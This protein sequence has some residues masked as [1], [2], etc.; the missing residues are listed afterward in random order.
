MIKKLIVQLLGVLHLVVF[1]GAILGGYFIPT[2]YL[3]AYLLFAPFLIMDWNDTDGRCYLTRLT[4]YIQHDKDME[5]GDIEFTSSLLK[6]FGFEV[7][8]KNIDTG[9]LNAI[10]FSWFAGMYRFVKHNKITV[11][12]NKQTKLLIQVVIIG[13]IL[14]N[15]ISLYLLHL[16]D[17]LDKSMVGGFFGK[18]IGNGIAMYRLQ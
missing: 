17:E 8:K 2:E 10:M 11:V 14:S 16:E 18:L 1:F 15:G 4:H 9:L 6:S 13:W 12:P 3:P 5:T 7:D